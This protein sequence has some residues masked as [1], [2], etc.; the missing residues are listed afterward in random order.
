MTASAQEAP[1][2][3]AA[4]I[5]PPSAPRLWH[6]ESS[7]PTTTRTATAARLPTDVSAPERLVEEIAA[8]SVSARRANGSARRS[9]YAI[10]RLLDV[11]ISLTAL[12]ALA[13]LMV[14]LGLLVKLESRGPALLMQRRVGKDGH[15]FALLKFRT[16]RVDAEACT[17]PVFATPNDPRCTRIGRFMRR[18]SLDELPQLINVLRG[19]MSI[20]GPRPERPYFVAQFEHG[21]PH[22]QE[23]HREHV[24]ITGWA[25][26]HGLRGDTSIE[27]RLAYD[28]Y[29]VEH[30][31]LGLDLEIMVRTIAEMLTGRNAC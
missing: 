7:L 24:G 13:P 26:V 11:G 19:E 30:W 5:A 18:H 3:H 27:E 15:V 6:T 8:V 20:V 12:I 1:A 17:G 31:S 22:Y 21:L 29:Y 2:V 14:V 23:R 16:M 28:L 25:Q 9:A 4:A 10:K